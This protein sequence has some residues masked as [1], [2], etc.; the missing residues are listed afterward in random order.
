MK[1]FAFL[2]SLAL[3][4]IYTSL[5]ITPALALYDPQTEPN[6]RF[7]IHIIQ[8]GPAEAVPA[9]ELVNSSGGDWG[10]ITFL[11]ESKDRN[12][13][14]WRDFFN[15]LR[16]KHL[17]PIVRLATEP[18][19]DFW[20][21]PYEGEEVAWADFLDKLPWPTKNR[22]IIIYNEPNHA[23]EWGN[24]VDPADYAKTLD[25]TIEALKSKN[26]DFFV[27]NAG[28]D[29]S[30]PEKQPD[31]MDS[32]N[33]MKAMN[34]AVPGIFNKLDGWSSHSYPNPAF[35]GS[36][37]ASGKGTI[38]T[39]HREDQILKD[40]GVNK[41]L[42]IFITETGW[43][44]AEGKT[45][46]NSLLSVE[47][48]AEYYK[49]A[50][51]K[52]WNNN[53]IVAVTPFL[54]DYKE[55]PFDHFAFIKATFQGDQSSE[56]KFHPQYFALRDLPKIKGEPLQENKAKFVKGSISKDNLLSSFDEASASSALR[57]SLV[58]GETYDI[59]LSVK[60]IG[61][62]IWNDMKKI[63]IIPSENGARFGIQSQDLPED[64][65]VEPDQSYT[66]NYKIT[67]PEGGEY[68]IFL[69]LLADDFLFQSP[70]LEVDFEV[71]SPVILKVE[72]GLKWKN[73]P[74]G[75]YLLS[76]YGQIKDAFNGTTDTIE[77]NI[78]GE[79]KEIEARYLLPD[80][81]YSFTLEKPFYKPKTITQTVSSGINEIEFGDLQPDISSAI[82]NPSQLWKL[83]P[84]SE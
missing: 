55:P 28:L 41:N 12:E 37:D 8:A 13:T 54:L 69:N 17:I 77:L 59:S 3:F 64:V 45:T 43:K 82:L 67:A 70:P 21:K 50:F 81:P 18:E 5:F 40:L 30:A 39:W 33:F 75:Q 20:K 19:G 71:K 58:A 60:N 36:P 63:R 24:S 34:E 9:R 66:F 53:R 38:R 56:E 29:A 31:Y 44:H 76:I 74:A 79:S 42:P 78:D 52:A 47:K 84:W 10:Y 16:R 27:I 46:N 4:L 11:I 7:G 6:N 51:N 72:G 23:T 14:K 15:E 25:K 80:K 62:S 2:L 48:V 65:K 57:T 49:D 35:S 68:K 26:P 83:L 61:Q 32:E 73:N 1:F 22:Y